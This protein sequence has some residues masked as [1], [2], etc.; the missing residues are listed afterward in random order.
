LN[1]LYPKFI[2]VYHVKRQQ[3]KDFD[4]IFMHN[5]QQIDQD[6][7]GPAKEKL[8]AWNDNNDGYKPME[9]VIWVFDEFLVMVCLI[10]YTK[11]HYD[12]LDELTFDAKLVSSALLKRLELYGYKDVEHDYQDRYKNLHLWR[13]FAQEFNCKD[14]GNLSVHDYDVPKPEIF[15]QAT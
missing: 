10:D 6:G 11:I 5:G 9:N 14:D 3:S 2:C 7:H 1:I 13:D 4:I 8:Q 15:F 12:Q